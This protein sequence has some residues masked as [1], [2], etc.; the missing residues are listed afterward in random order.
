[1]KVWGVGPLIARV[2]LLAQGERFRQTESVTPPESR[3]CLTRTVETR[4][5][6]D[7]SPGSPFLSFRARLFLPQDSLSAEY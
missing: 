4:D 6:A 1:M 7:P 3:R 5:G 2:G